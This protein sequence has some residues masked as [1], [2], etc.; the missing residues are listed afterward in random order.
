[1][2]RLKSLGGWLERRAENILALLLGSMFAAFIIQ[3]IFRYFLNLPLGWTVEYV[4][5]AW[6]WGIFFGYTFVVKPDDAIRLDI[7]YQLVPISARRVMD[8]LAGLAC[9]GI[10]A[11]SIPKAW[12]FVTFMAIERTSFMRIRF[13]IVFSVYIPFALAVVVRSLMSA[14]RAFKGRP[15]HHDPLEVPVSDEHA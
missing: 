12:D 8:V 9:A 7:V 14:W 13:D 1:M 3:I 10:F 6:L 5:I 2:D 15:S 4:T 11:W